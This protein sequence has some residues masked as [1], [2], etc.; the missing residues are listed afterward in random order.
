MTRRRI[1]FYRAALRS[2]GFCS[3]P[4][5]VR[6]GSRRGEKALGRR[7]PEVAGMKGL[8]GPGRDAGAAGLRHL[9]GPGRALCRCEPLGEAGRRP[10]VRS[11]PQV[12]GRHGSPIRETASPPGRPGSC[13]WAPHTRG[14]SVFRA[15]GASTQK[16]AD[17]VLL[18][19]HAAV[20]EGSPGSDDLAER[21]PSAV[22][23]WGSA[24]GRGLA[25]K[26]QGFFSF[27][28]SG[29]EPSRTAGGLR[30]LRVSAPPAWRL[31]DPRT[32]VQTRNQPA[33]SATGVKINT[34]Y[35]S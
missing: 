22:T 5:R 20:C 16:C 29:A 27:S 28:A 23:T 21:T 4:L 24:G 26:T 1:K 6:A 19:P 8:G 35:V 32:S 31:W 9:C 30:K 3:E 33:L 2:C 34:G 14:L 10:R 7:S 25:L 17:G 13:L 12:L 18:P 11:G 15:W